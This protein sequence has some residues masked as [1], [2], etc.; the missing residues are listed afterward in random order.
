[1]LN[2]ARR[3]ASDQSWGTGRL[4]AATESAPSER[5][6]RR[7]ALLN[8]GQDRD[9]RYEASEV[10]Q[11][12]TL[13]S[14]GQRRLEAANPLIRALERATERDLSSDEIATVKSWRVTTARR[15]ERLTASRA[16][17]TTP[18][19]VVLVTAVCDLDRPI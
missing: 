7:P 2:G 6:Q 19:D 18:P 14:E 11:Q 13:T 17:Y 16:A 8:Y 9:N 4:S 10:D 3:K 15:P 5:A 1:M 12:A